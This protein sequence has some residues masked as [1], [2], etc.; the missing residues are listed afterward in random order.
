MALMELEE[1]RRGDYK[2]QGWALLQHHL[3]FVSVTNLRWQTIF[4][5]IMALEEVAVT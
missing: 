3:A 4:G 5:T 2:E 1:W